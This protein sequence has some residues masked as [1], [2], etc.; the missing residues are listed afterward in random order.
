MKKVIAKFLKDENIGLSYFRVV[1]VLNEKCKEAFPFPNSCF[2]E[3]SDIYINN[4][5]I[6]NNLDFESS[7][8]YKEINKSF[9]IFV[10]EVNDKTL[11]AFDKGDELLFPKSSEGLSFHVRP[12]AANSND[13]FEFS[14]GN[15]ITKRTFWANKSTVEGL[16]KNYN[17]N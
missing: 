6:I 1:R 13:T 9:P 10:V 17:I 16:I 14:N 15:Q 2:T 4:K 5:N 11:E 12:K 3:I 7:K 8:F